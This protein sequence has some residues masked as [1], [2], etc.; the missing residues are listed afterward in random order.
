MIIST[1]GPNIRTCLVAAR[2]LMQVQ[3]AGHQ[4]KRRSGGEDRVYRIEL[5]SG[6]IVECTIVEHSRT[7]A[8]FAIEG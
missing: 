2:R 4:E 3:L 8:C 7:E 5:E 1:K 6:H